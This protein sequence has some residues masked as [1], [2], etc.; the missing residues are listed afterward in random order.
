M[1]VTVSLTATAE[2]ADIRQWNADRYGERRADEY[3]GFPRNS[4]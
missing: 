4:L 1:T 3:V 2:L